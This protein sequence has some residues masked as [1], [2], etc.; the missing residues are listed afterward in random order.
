MF[1]NHYPKSIFLFIF[2]IEW[3]T[4]T[5]KGIHTHMLTCIDHS[6]YYITVAQKGE[7]S[8]LESTNWLVKESGVLG[9][10][11]YFTMPSI[12]SLQKKKILHRI[13]IVLET[14]TIF[15]YNMNPPSR[16]LTFSWS[17][18]SFL[19]LSVTSSPLCLA[20]IGPELSICP[21]TIFHY[22]IT[23]LA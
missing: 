12:P 4:W 11:S 20:I 19:G 14:W 1:K 22:L 10:E 5:Q 2:T 3:N 23:H 15:P 6:C 21:Q 16:N 13:F 9:T 7:M 8:C 17:P 18:Q